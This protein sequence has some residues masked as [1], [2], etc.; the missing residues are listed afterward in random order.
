MLRDG[1]AL[2]GKRI[3]ILN[4]EQAGNFAADQSELSDFDSVRPA[5]RAPRRQYSGVPAVAT[6]RM[7]LP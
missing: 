4:E 6:F 7:R 5:L 1:P 3:L 2:Q